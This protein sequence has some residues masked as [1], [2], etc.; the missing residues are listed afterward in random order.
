MALIDSI[1][2]AVGDQAAAAL[3][4][5]FGGRKVYVPIIS[6]QA[7]SITRAIGIVASVAL[8]RRFGGEYIDVPNLQ[9]SGPRA[10]LRRQILDLAEADKDIAQTAIAR[11][12][13]CSR[14]WVSRVLRGN[15]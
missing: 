1:R 15:A 3:V 7:H 12:L 6:S 11:Q 8:S 2:E 9:P 13:K 14:Q 4:K 10:I 5:S